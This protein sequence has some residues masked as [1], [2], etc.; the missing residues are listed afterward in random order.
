MLIAFV[1]LPLGFVVGLVVGVRVARVGEVA[2]GIRRLGVAL[3][4]MVAIVGVGVGLAWLTADHPPT[5]EGH[6][7]ELAFEVRLP[8]GYPVRDSLRE[9]D[10]RVGVVVS[11][12]DRAF[13]Q[14][15]FDRVRTDG[16]FR[17][18]P[19]R[20]GLRS[21]G[22][23]TMSLVHRSDDRDAGETQFLDLPLAP[24][25]GRGDLEWSGWLPFRTR[26]DGQPIPA[27]E[28]AEVRYRVRRV[29]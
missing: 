3:G 2:A 18:V 27:A 21:R 28:R 11:S 10:L 25:P 6:G 8:P 1:Y 4:L 13:S 20:A 22:F 14:L 15:D 23:R 9:H 24:S 17:V 29:D 12:S 26:S 19:G 7:L 5:L 16:A